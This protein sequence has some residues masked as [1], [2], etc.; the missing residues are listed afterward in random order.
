MSE[1]LFAKLVREFM[2]PELPVNNMSVYVAVENKATTIKRQTRLAVK[3]NESTFDPT[4]LVI[5]GLSSEIIIGMDWL[6]SH[7]GTVDVEFKTI[8]IAGKILPKHLV[9][10]YAV[11]DLRD[12]A[13]VR[14]LSINSLSLEPLK[15]QLCHRATMTMTNDENVSSTTTIPALGDA[16][17]D[18][19][20]VASV[21]A[22]E[23]NGSDFESKIDKYLGGV[24]HL[25]E[26][27]KKRVKRL[28][29]NYRDVF[30]DKPDCT[31]VYAHK[32]KMM[33]NKPILKK[34][35]P[36]AIH[37]RDALRKLF[38]KL[39]AMGIIERSQSQYCNPLRIVTK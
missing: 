23:T 24:D 35:Y 11:N 2:V 30:S 7:R 4:L 5:P 20:F 1:A 9:T 32:L 18:H 26:S 22:V 15:Q 3:I 17:V 16:R 10:F 31:H 34:S 37:Q 33:K 12:D 29:L 28:F 13:R 36:V 6:D 14:V 39:L 25:D 27:Q 21:S 38:Q 8:R 19:R